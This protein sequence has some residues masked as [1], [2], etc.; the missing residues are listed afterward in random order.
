MGRRALR[1][2]DPSLDLSG[3]WKDVADLVDS[4]QLDTLIDRSAPL[5]V[6]VGSGKGLFLERATGE[7][8]EHNFVGIEVSR[9]YSR[10]SAARLARRERHHALMLHGDAFQVFAKHI[11]EASLHAV[12]VYFP[13]PWW[14]KKHHKRRIM[15]DSFLQEVVRTLVPGGRLHFWTD[16]QAY[17][18]EALECIRAF[19]QLEGPF[20]VV[21]VA[22]AHDLDFQSH[23]ERRT[24][25]DNLPVYRSEFERSQGR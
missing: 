25:L 15:Q 24:R 20:E 23:F 4:W 16:V 7:R 8:P 10:F 1:K 3:H 22:A 13:D 19:P 18:E 5:E 11:R 12:H 2:I 9:K 14:K 6:E 17:F 21:E